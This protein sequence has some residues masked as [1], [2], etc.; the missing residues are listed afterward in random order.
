MNK[1]LAL[2]VARE[3][4]ISPDKAYTI[5]KSFHDG[6]RELLSHPVDCKGGILIKGFMRFRFKEI[7]LEHM[8]SA[9]G[10]KDLEYKKQVL[11]N[12]KKY[13]RNETSNQKRQ[14]QTENHNA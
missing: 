9:A 2:E 10:T 13:K 4:N 14:A 5:C 7:K 11:S 12:I 1:A 3:L 6:M 8:I